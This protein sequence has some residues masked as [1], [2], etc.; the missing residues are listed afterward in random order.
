MLPVTITDPV[1]IAEPV[2]SNV[3]AFEENDEPDI[4]TDPVILNILPL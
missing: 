4:D 1:I 2:I 3:S